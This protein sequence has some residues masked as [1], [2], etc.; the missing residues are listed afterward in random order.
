YLMYSLAA[1]KELRS[2]DRDTIARSLRDPAFRQRYRDGF[3]N[4]AKGL[5][6]Y[7]DWRIVDVAQVANPANLALEGRSI[8]DIARERGA[9][10]VDVFFDLGLEEDL[11]TVF[12]AKVMNS[13]EAA[14][15]KL[16]RSDASV[17]AQSDA[18]AHLE[19]FCDA[20]FG[21][22]FFARWVRDLK[23]MSLAEAVHRVTGLPATLYRIPDRGRI[24][25]GAFADL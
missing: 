16:I 7:G 22:Y 15:A 17:I 1:W 6:F 24:V 4:P 18:G 11:A 9:D 8:A 19:F 10:P 21:L 2:A 23:A 3:K 13:D 25:E 12:N 20:G 5:I 14:V